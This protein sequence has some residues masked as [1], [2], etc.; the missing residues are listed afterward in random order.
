MHPSR[1]TGYSPKIPPKERKAWIPA[2]LR[3]ITFETLN[4]NI[5][6]PQKVPRH[7]PAKAKELLESHHAISQELARLNSKRERLRLSRFCGQ[8]TGKRK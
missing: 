8:A 6:L 7:W 1:P 5:L 4:D 3:K 2:R